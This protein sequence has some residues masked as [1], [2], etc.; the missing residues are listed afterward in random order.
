MN[1]DSLEK[2]LMLGKIEKE[3]RTSEDEMAGRHHWCNEH[4]LGQNPGDG[5][6]Q[7]GL[8]CCSPW[9]CKKLDMTRQLNNN[10]NYRTQNAMTCHIHK[11]LV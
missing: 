1:S 5:E 6:G 10:N 9:G 2:S 3:K 8:S 11:S 7:G 4:E